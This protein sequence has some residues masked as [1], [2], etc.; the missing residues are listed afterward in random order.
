MKNFFEITGND[1]NEK[2]N[3]AKKEGL[4]IYVRPVNSNEEHYYFFENE[5]Q[6]KAH[7]S[8]FDEEEIEVW[9]L[10]YQKELDA[11]LENRL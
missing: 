6:A 7:T 3:N 2:I 10:N 8:K 11:L 9:D 1:L 5:Q 4:N